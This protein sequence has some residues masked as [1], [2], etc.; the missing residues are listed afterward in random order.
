MEA[1]ECDEHLIWIKE[2][3]FV[4]LA[5]AS[6]TVADFLDR[7]YAVMLR[8]YRCEYVCKNEIVRGLFLAGEGAGAGTVL[9][10]FPV[11]GWVRV[12]DLVV[13]TETTTAYEVKSPLDS[14]ARV[15]GQTEMSLRLFDRVVVVCEPA[16]VG[17][18]A[19]AVDGRVG[20]VSLG[21]DGRF[22]EERP[23]LENRAVGSSQRRSTTRCGGASL[24]VRCSG[25]WGPCRPRRGS[26][27]MTFGRRFSSSSEGRWRTWS[28]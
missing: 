12:V 28:C 25:M 2:S 16:V 20:L 6:V 9:S 18:V 27:A 1:V 5:G 7:L 15:V 21:A 10:E 14:L 23:A 8:S 19:A 22:T 3:P 17:A 24:R 13:V 11:A 4:A 26:I